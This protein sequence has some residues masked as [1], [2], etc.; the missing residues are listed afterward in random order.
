M[1]GKTNFFILIISL[2]LLSFRLS[3]QHPNKQAQEARKELAEAKQDSAS[4]YKEFKKES[5]LKIKENEKHIAELKA[6]K[7][8]E[9]KEEQE[10]Y[11]VKV[12]ALKKKNNELKKKMQDYTHGNISEW[13]AFKL[14]FN[15]SMEEIGQSIKEIMQSDK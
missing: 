6:K 15:R 1:S 2:S 13:A 9:N 11:N 5:E 3:A 14:E 8:N 7:K 12:E 10:K 4:D